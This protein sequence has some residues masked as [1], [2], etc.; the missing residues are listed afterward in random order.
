MAEIRPDRTDLWAQ[1]PDREEDTP[2]PR[3][4]ARSI[5]T[6]FADLFAKAEM[7]GHDLVF[8][9]GRARRASRRVA[10]AR[11]PAAVAFRHDHAARTGARRA[12]GTDLPGVY[13]VAWASVS[14]VRASSKTEYGL[15]QTRIE[16]RRRSA[17][18]RHPKHT[19][20]TEG[21]WLKCDGCREIIWKK[22]LESTAQRLRQVRPSFPHGCARAAHDAF[23]RRR[24]RGAGRRARIYRSA[25]VR[26]SEILQGAA[27]GHRRPRPH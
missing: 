18:P 26:R 5:P 12:G 19:V 20:R 22:D 15:V 25:A 13:N 2:R 14:R 8:A 16:R 6:A 27:Q 23:R 7:L 21:L 1:T 11:R 24:L 3:W 4:A 10:R 17:R 9:G